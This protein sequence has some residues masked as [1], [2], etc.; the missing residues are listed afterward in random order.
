MG[1]REDVCVPLFYVPTPRPKVYRVPSPEGFPRG[2]HHTQT[3][4]VSRAAAYFLRVAGYAGSSFKVLPYRPHQR[5][6]GHGTTIRGSEWGPAPRGQAESLFCSE[7]WWLRLGWTSCPAPSKTGGRPPGR[8]RV[9]ESGSCSESEPE[10][11][12]RPVPVRLL[13][14]SDVRLLKRLTLPVR[15]VPISMEDAYLE[16]VRAV[17]DSVAP[18][19][20]GSTAKHPFNCLR[21][22]GRPLQ[23]RVES[24]CCRTS[25]ILTV[26]IQSCRFPVCPPIVPVDLSPERQQLAQNAAAL[27]R[28]ESGSPL[29]RQDVL[30]AMSVPPLCVAIVVMNRCRDGSDAQS[31]GVHAA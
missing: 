3:V 23:L 18:A 22:H 25:S 15:A 20:H 6:S 2:H 21:F 4:T 19:K 1:K 7:S 17:F 12:L 8:L 24:H 26:S 11:Q 9:S 14:D 10:S 28:V 16:N 13:T 29:T 5:K 30:V 31:A 27:T